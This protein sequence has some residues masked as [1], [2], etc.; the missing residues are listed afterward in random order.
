[1]LF[2]SLFGVAWRNSVVCHSRRGPECPCAGTAALD[3]V[4]GFAW[5]Q[6]Q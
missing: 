1:M 4:I 5:S 6:A 2:L 3:R